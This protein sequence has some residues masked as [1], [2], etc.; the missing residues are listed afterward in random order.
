MLHAQGSGARLAA[1]S[2]RAKRLFC[3]ASF[4]VQGELLRSSVWAHRGGKP[5]FARLMLTV[6]WFLALAPLASADEVII[7]NP[8]VDVSEISANAARAIFGMRLRTWPDGQPIK[9]FVLNDQSSVH[10]SFAKQKL[11]IFSH[12]L[13]RA[14]D[15]LVYSGTGQSPNEVTSEQAMLARVATTPGAIGYIT[16][17]KVDDSVHVVEIK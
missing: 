7:A 5:L 1:D 15:R 10:R 17:D 12:Q 13:R 16:R 4:I 2:P 14:W 6:F 9:V 11:S 8:S 3:F